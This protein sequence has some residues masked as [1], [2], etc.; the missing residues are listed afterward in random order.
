MAICDSFSI[1]PKYCYRL[2]PS[3]DIH[4]FYEMNTKGS[5]ADSLEYEFLWD[6]IEKGF[7]L[8]AQTIILQ[9]PCTVGYL[10]RQVATPS[11]RMR[12]EPSAPAD[13][14]R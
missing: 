11:K 14:R 6:W 7:R 3:D 5:P 13:S 1:P 4:R 10:V 2:K 12:S 8:D 9:R